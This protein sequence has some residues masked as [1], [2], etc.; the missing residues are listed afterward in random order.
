M[1][2]NIYGKKSKSKLLFL[3]KMDRSLAG[4][5]QGHTFKRCHVN[6]YNARNCSGHVEEAMY[7]TDKF[8]LL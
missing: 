5:A 4:V 2:I 1:E 6:I 8:T 3:F 7:Q